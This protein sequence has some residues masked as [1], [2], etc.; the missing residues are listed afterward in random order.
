MWCTLHP[1]PQTYIELG[2]PKNA[3][4]VKVQYLKRI[5]NSLLWDMYSF[6]KDRIAFKNKGIVND[7]ELFHGTRATDPL[8]LSLSEEGF[9]I[10]RSNIGYWGIANYLAD[11]AKYFRQFAYTS[12]TGHKEI[13]LAKV[14]HVLG[15]IYDYGSQ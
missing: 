10:R 12:I 14:I 8:D 5:Q 2:A 13:I 11:I 15:H 1:H 6:N 9:D 4:D 7:T 3:I